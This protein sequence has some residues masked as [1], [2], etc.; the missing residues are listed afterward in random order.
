MFSFLR[1]VLFV[2][3]VL[4]APAGEAPL[5][6]AGPSDGEPR[7]PPNARLGEGWQLVVS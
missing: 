2:C 3:V 4:R 1:R 7:K 5:G 6:Q